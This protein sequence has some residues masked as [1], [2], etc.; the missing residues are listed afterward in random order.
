MKR[1][2]DELISLPSFEERY[3]YLKLPG[4]IGDPTFGGR[5]YMNQLLYRTDQWKS[6]R[7]DVIIR[8][9][10]CDL[11]HKDYPIALEVYVHHINP[12]TVEDILE[13]RSCVF[14]MNNLIS[15]SFRTHNGIH[16]GREGEQIYFNPA[17]RK[18][19]DTCPWR[20]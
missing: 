2:Y 14:D 15:T 4:V 11:A 10:G 19:Y 1:T 20:N 3:N 5:R 6:I 8:D 12:I 13:Q 17:E 9:E 16:Y 7:D 18:P